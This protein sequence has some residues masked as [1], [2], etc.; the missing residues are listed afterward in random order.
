MEHR[1]VRL[2]IEALYIQEPSIACLHDHRDSELSTALADGD[3]EVEVV[4][5]LHQEIELVTLKQ[6]GIDI[7]LSD[8]FGEP[9]DLQVGVDL[10]HLTDCQYALVE[11]EVRNP[12]SHPVKFGEDKMIVVGPPKRPAN[13]F[14]CECNRSHI[15][16]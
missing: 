15:P 6:K 4:T 10:I 12:A 3:L 1:T 5:F 14:Q 7:F 2:K 11:A 9:L 13:P 8:P 16:H